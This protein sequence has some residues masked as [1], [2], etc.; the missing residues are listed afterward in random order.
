MNYGQNSADWTTY[1][2]FQPKDGDLANVCQQLDHGDLAGIFSK[3]KFSKTLGTDI[4]LVYGTDRQTGFPLT[5]G[6]SNY[7]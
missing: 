2:H 5:I 6:I 4:A 3:C 7:S 1:C